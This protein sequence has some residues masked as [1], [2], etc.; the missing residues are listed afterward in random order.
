MFV[1]YYNRAYEQIP[2]AILCQEALYGSCKKKKN[3]SI[4]AAASDQQV[5]DH[6]YV[7][8]SYPPPGESL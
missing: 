3:L 4:F 7:F 5:S 8:L 1:N 2:P 6:F